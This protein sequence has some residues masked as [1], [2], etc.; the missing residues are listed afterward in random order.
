MIFTDKDSLT[1]YEHP[2]AV[3]MID[4][5]D[6]F[7]SSVEYQMNPMVV[8]RRFTNPVEAAHWLNEMYQSSDARCVPIRVGYDSNTKGSNAISDFDLQQIHRTVFDPN[9]FLF[10]AVIVVDFS[11]NGMDGLEFCQSISH[12]PC[13]KILFTGVATRNE[14]VG[15]LKSGLIDSFLGK[16]EV[17]A[18]DRLDVEIDKMVV[19]YFK[20]LAKPIKDILILNKYAFLADPVVADRVEQIKVMEGYLEHYLMPDPKGFLLVDTLGRCKVMVIETREGLDRHYAA[21]KKAG[22]PAA[23]LDGL[24]AGTLV[25]YFWETPGLYSSSV[26]DWE[27]CC[28]PVEICLGAER[29]FWALFDAPNSLIDRPIFS[30][31]QRLNEKYLS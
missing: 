21:A 9:R 8:P 27:A 25:P 7:M 18:L 11:M 1:V 13:K 26:T 30:Y 12:L 29:Y 14:A 10:P 28:R 2:T 4:D 20:G 6:M 3:L 31:T 19:K 15:A 5:N 22:A 16:N 24:S 23:L 17:H